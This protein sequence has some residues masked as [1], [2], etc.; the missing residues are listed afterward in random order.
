VQ[1]ELELL[2]AKEEQLKQTFTDLAKRQA[3][4]ERVSDDA[5]SFLE[6]WQDV[7]ELLEAA[8]PEE[9]L[10]LLQHYI[11][12][13]ELGPIDSETRTSSYARRLFPEVRP[14]RGFDFAGDSSIDSAPGPERTNVAIHA[15][16][17]GSAC[18]N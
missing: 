6:T 9:R 2:E 1:A 5:R 7:G 8:T 11:E 13:V 3:P 15:N 4:I 10:Q 17:N 14:D 16:R 12:A 18:V